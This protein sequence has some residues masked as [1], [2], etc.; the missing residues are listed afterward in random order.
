MESAW[1]SVRL[2]QFPH[3]ALFRGSRRAFTLIELL[4]V[5]GII[6]ILAAVALPNFLEARTRAQVARVRADL[7]SLEI[8][9]EAYRLTEN[10]YPPGPIPYKYP[11]LQTET[12]RLTTPIAYLASVPVDGFV[13]PPGP[14]LPGGPFGLGGVYLHYLN[15]EAELSLQES[16]LAF[17]YG[18]DGQMSAD[19]TRYDP[20]NGAV[21]AGDIYKSG[22]PTS[23]N[24]VAVQ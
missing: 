5:V 21:S 4:V 1:K 13:K 12:W 6:A 24:G 2:F 23:K 3:S 18:P 10:H 16:W 22:A 9:L 20:T 11:T 14:P 7:R 19:A 15:G 17:S 8:G